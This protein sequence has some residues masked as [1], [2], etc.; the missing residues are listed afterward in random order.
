MVRGMAYR[1]RDKPP[2]SAWLTAERTRR[3]WKA[4]EVARR[5]RELGY[6]AE[7]STYRT[8]EAGR[9]PSPD[10]IAALERLFESAAPGENEP[11]GDAAGLVRAMTAALVATTQA[12]TDVRLEL[13]DARREAEDQRLAT[14][15][16]IGR[17][18]SQLDELLAREGMQAG[19]VDRDR[20]LP[21]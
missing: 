16:L 14:A 7:E 8:W 9:R 3:G 21:G 19:F 1:R 2:F 5:L 13:A 15:E 11:G 12:I 10:T 17:L 4:P 20:H 18:S 6:Q